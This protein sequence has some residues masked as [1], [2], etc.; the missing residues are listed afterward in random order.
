MLL[1]HF[2]VDLVI[3]YP[4]DILCGVVVISHHVVDAHLVVFG[5]RSP[6]ALNTVSSSSS[7]IIGR[8]VPK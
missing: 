3:A 8:W 4:D 5:K 6:P 1:E 7:R 2:N